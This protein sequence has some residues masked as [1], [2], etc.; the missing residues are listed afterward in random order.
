MNCRLIL[1]LTGISTSP[2]LA[3]SSNFLQRALSIRR[4]QVKLRVSEL[5]LLSAVNLKL[6]G[7]FFLG[8]S[9]F[10]ADRHVY[11]GIESPTSPQLDI[12]AFV[13]VDSSS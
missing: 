3:L 2:R 13:V 1:L 11:S 10:L 7:V 6:P 4:A 9:Y 12:A 5:S 8:F